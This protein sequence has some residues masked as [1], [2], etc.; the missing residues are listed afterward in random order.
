MV[1]SL[2]FR[3]HQCLGKMVDAKRTT[4]TRLLPYLRYVDVQWD[5][6]NAVNLPQIDIAAEEHERYTVRVGDLLVCEGRHLGRAAFWRAELPICA[7]QKALHRLRPSDPAND[8]SRY[9]FYCLYVVHFKDA[10]VPA[11]MTTASLHRRSRDQSRYI[12]TRGSPLSIEHGRQVSPKLNASASIAPG[13]SLTSSPASSMCAP[14][15]HVYRRFHPRRRTKDLAEDA[16]ESESAE[17]D[18]AEAE[19]IA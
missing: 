2:R 13:S 10:S 15:L 12:W 17:L 1:A 9:L 3:Y 11:Q 8:S 14:R 5:R 16:V 19:V 7:F 4:G 18:H 6:I